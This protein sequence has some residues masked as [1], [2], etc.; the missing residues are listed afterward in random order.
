[1]S[2]EETD[3][4]D[5]RAAT[6]AEAIEKEIKKRDCANRILSSSTVATMTSAFRST[7]VIVVPDSRH[8]L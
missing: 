8:L 1:M 5:R 3:K 4:T 7:F 2:F 6:T